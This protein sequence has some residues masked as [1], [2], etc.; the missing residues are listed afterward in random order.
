MLNVETSQLSVKFYIQDLCITRMKYK[1][2]KVN[3][4]YTNHHLGFHTISLSID[5]PIFPHR[6]QVLL[7]SN[8]NIV[9]L[10]W[11]TILTK[12]VE[13]RGSS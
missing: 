12:R 8:V 3:F 9:N 5:I 2:L 10:V 13:T 4:G 1:A 6:E 7:K 11:C